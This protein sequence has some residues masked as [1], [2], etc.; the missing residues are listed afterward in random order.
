M[1]E[2]TNAL[3]TYLNTQKHITAC[4]IYTLKLQNGNVYR[5]AD[6]DTDVFYGGYTYSHTMMGIPKK[7]ADKNTIASNCGFYDSRDLQ[8][9]I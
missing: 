7:T 1:K 4:D 9:A 5:F 2:A 8:H 3:I 6:F